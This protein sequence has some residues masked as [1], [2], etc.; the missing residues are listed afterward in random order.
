MFGIAVAL[1]LWMSRAPPGR[2]CAG[3]RS[4]AIPAVLLALYFTYSRGGL[5]ALLV[6]V[7]LPARPLARPALA[8][9]DAGDRRPR[10]AARGARRAGA[11]QPRQQPRRPGVGRPG[12]HGAADPARRHRARAGPLRRRCARLERSEGALTGRALELSRHPTL[13][14]AIGAGRRRDRDRRSRSPSAA[15]P[16]TSSRAPTSSS[17]NEPSQHFSELSAAPAATTSGG[18]RSTPSRKSRC[19][20]TAPAPTSSPGTSSGSIDLPVHDAH[21]LYLEAF[22]ELGV[23]GGLLVLGL[24]GGAALVRLLRL[25]RRRASPSASARGALRGD[26]RLRG[27]R[28]LRL[29]LGDRRAGRDLLPRRRGRWSRPAARNWPP[30]ASA[31]S[32]GPSERRYGLAVAGLAI[33]WI[34]ALALVGPLLVDHEIDA[35][36]DAAAGRRPR[37]AR[38]TTPTRPARSSPGR[39]PP[40][41]S[42]AC[43]PNCRATTDRDRPTSTRRSNARTDNWQLVLPALAGSSTRPA[44]KRPPR[45]TSTRPGS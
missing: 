35:S 42:S 7:G 11:R 31:G 8:A 43:S 32:G 23:V 44:T 13:L 16:G 6:A 34:A 30:T 21:S 2:R 22:A 5:L 27:R 41:S 38:S 20:G 12:R 9:G 1:L 28:R 37:R 29:V 25:A 19:S 24:V 45:P 14:K 40:T 39:P 18:S 26:A 33:A 15:A 3:S 17:P 10:G 4:A 36:Q